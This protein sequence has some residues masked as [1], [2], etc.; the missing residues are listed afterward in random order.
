M[1]RRNS[2]PFILFSQ[3][4]HVL[5][6]RWSGGRLGT[7][8][9]EMPILLLTTIG[10]KSGKKRSRALTYY[11]EAGDYFLAASNG[12]SDFHP[13]WW[14]NLKSN[15]LA[16]IMVGPQHINVRASELSGQTRERFWDQFVAME[17]RYNSYKKLTKRK[18]PVIRLAVES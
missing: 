5:L 8:L 9:L 4:F 1:K 18:I 10:R 16:E 12:G 17:S 2:N 3:T 11:L 6:Y 7:R 13:L 15:P 14:L